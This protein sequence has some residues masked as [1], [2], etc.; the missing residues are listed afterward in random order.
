[1][2][3]AIKT[4]VSVFLKSSKG[5]ENLGGKEFQSLVKGQLKNIL[6]GSE[7]NEAVKNMRQQLDNNQDGKVGFQEYM[8]LIG[9]LAQ[10]LSEQRSLEKETQP[11]SS[12][13]ETQ[14]EVVAN[15]QAEPAANAQAEP[16]ANAQAEPPKAEPQAAKEVEKEDEPVT[17][18]AAA[19]EQKPEEEKKT[20]VEQEGV[21]VEENKAEEKNK[22]E[23]AS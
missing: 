14:A 15:A 2:E 5:K 18:E 19:E 22:T 23:E 20:D 12:T 8:N 9:Y 6:T 3:A 1:M 4:V 21:K 10:T 13:Q 7:D 16:A 17:E 11:E